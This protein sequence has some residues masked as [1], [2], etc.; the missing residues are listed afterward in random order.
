MHEGWAIA[1]CNG[2]GCYSAVHTVL[3]GTCTICIVRRTRSFLQNCFSSRRPPFVWVP[4]YRLRTWSYFYTSKKPDSVGVWLMCSL[5]PRWLGSGST[6]PNYTL[7]QFSSVSALSA[8]CFLCIIASSTIDQQKS[9]FRTFRTVP[10]NRC[11]QLK[12]RTHVFSPLP[13]RVK[14]PGTPEHAAHCFSALQHRQNHATV[15]VHCLATTRLE[16][17]AETFV[18]GLTDC[19]RMVNWAWA[20]VCHIFDL[21]SLLLSSS[22][23]SPF[24]HNRY[25]PVLF[26]LA[27]TLMIKQYRPDSTP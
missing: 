13:V 9:T 17:F 25:H 21:E 19:H 26:S 12:P 27:S 20:V 1:Y 23:S 7:V 22:S 6:H 24:V 8:T 10:L 2:P 14:I 4:R 16:T 5:G 3:P 18:V 11:T 15:P